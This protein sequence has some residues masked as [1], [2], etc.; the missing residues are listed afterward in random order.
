[1][2]LS[3]KFKKLERKI[4]PLTLGPKSVAFEV[5]EG[6]EANI[7]NNGTLSRVTPESHRTCFEESK[8]RSAYSYKLAVK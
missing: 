1:M 4:L 2:L 7:L 5:R 8:L 3:F 6:N